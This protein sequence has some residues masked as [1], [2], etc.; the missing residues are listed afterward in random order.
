MGGARHLP[1]LYGITRAPLLR[2]DG[3]IHAAVGYDA[4][5]GL[6][7]ED[8]PDVGA[9]VPKK[10]SRA[11]AQ[12]SLRLLRETFSTFC[13]GDADMYV[14]VQG[15]H[16]GDVRLAPGVDESAFLVALLT[17][18]CRAS[19]VLAPGCVIRAAAM[20]G[21]GAGKGLLARCICQVA[22]GQDGAGN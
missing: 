16:V 5:T 18:V 14:D 4:P 8:V 6:W 20:S 22:F 13:F 11:D 17:A 21:A 12:A 7:C 3:S 19:L 10:P 15:V 1:A 9:L 2:N